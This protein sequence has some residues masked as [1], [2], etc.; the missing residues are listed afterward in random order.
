MKIFKTVLV[1]FLIFIL[2]GCGSTDEEEK[3]ENKEQEQEERWNLEG[4]DRPKTDVEGE[5]PPHVQRYVGSIRYDYFE[6]AY[7]SYYAEATRENI[8]NFYEQLATER[9]QTLEYDLERNPN[10]YFVIDVEDSSKVDSFGFIIN[11]EEDGYI[12]WTV[13]A[14]EW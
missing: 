5:D 13:T 11:K 10:L 12:Y 14:A 7:A 8:V 2:V 1:L 9:N 4:T 6:N 3:T